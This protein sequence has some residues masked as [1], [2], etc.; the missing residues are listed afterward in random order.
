M[1]RRTVVAVVML[2]FTGLMPF[3]P[4]SAGAAQGTPE[5][6]DPNDTHC[7]AQFDMTLSPG[8]SMAPTTGTLTSHG[9]SGT[10]TCDG[11][12]DG[13]SVTGVG[14]RGEDGRYGIGAMGPTSCTSSEGQGEFAFSFTMPTTA[15]PQRVSG[16]FLATYGPL[17][18]G[19]LYGG[20][21][22]GDRMYGKFTVTPIEGDCV[23][24][25]ITK[26]RLHCDEW[27]VNE[28]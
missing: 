13:Q 17:Q 14:T 5:N 21:F 4:A 23:T 8:L 24:T 11:P 28:R 27:V 12:I 6:P 26:V 10:N 7:L 25:P 2:M 22:T 19:H 1:G 16:T 9:E 20:T 15:G 18:G 3:A